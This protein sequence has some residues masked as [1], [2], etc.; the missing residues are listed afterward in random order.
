MSEDPI[1]WFHFHRSREKRN[2]YMW[3]KVEERKHCILPGDKKVENTAYGRRC[4]CTVTF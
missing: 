2:N 4:D 1:S 3:S